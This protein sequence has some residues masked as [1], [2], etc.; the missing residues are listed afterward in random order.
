MRTR[1]LVP[2]LVLLVAALALG[3]GAVVLAGGG[4]GGQGTGPAWVQLGPGGAAAVRALALEGTCPDLTV[5]G[6]AR[7]MA[8]RAAAGP[9]FPV[10]VCEAGLPAGASAVTVAGRGLRLPTANPRRML[11]LGDTGCRLSR[12]LTQACNDPALWPFARVAASAAAWQPDVVVHLGDYYYRE[13]ACPGASAGCEGSPWGDN[14]AAW[15][16]DFFTP[17][18]PLLG[19]AP[20]VFVRGN[21]EACSRG[22][23]GWFRFFDPSP[24][25]GACHDRT[26]P[27]TLPLGA[28]QLLMLD[29]SA[30]DD[31][32]ASPADVA[33]YGAQ[34]ARLR[35]AAGDHAWLVTH[36]P[37]RAVLTVRGSARLVG[38]ATLQAAARGNLPPNLE[39]VLAGHV[40]LFEALGLATEPALH[41]VVGTGGDRLDDDVAGQV[42]GLSAADV[43]VAAGRVLHHFGFVG[44]EPADG[45]WKATVYDVD[46]Q[47][48]TTC[49][50]APL[51]RCTP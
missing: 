15:N 42:A 38:N 22:G 4:G 1:L 32:H 37:I 16:A 10:A 24:R 48:L 25:D 28:L 14:W 31:F 36:R 44:L 33:N 20:W 35:E 9:G 18:T 8:V 21:H 40:H 6:A 39:A 29:S 41:L 47:V 5:D 19:A 2:R 34:L 17:A 50:L 46:G 26:P 23:Q 45:S 11:V 13:V 3:S 30:A 7:P 27:Y 49:S 12:S 43:A 51:P